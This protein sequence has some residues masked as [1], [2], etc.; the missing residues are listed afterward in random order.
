MKCCK[1]GTLT[2]GMSCCNL[3]LFLKDIKEKV[4]NT[5][6]PASRGC[7]LGGRISLFDGWNAGCTIPLLAG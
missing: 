7:I 5:I 6:T 2:Q 1:P 3:Q 4:N